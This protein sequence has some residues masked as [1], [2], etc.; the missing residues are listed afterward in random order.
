MQKL[1]ATVSSRIYSRPRANQNTKIP[2]TNMY[3]Q[4]KYQTTL[5][6]SNHAPH[7]LAHAFV[8]TCK[9]RE[10]IIIRNSD[11]QQMLLLELLE[12]CSLARLSPRDLARATWHNRPREQ[13]RQ[14]LKHSLIITTVQIS[15]T[16]WV[17]N[18]QKL[19]WRVMQKRKHHP[20]GDAQ[21][22][23]DPLLGS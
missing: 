1:T 5:I 17:P 15:F 13:V 18:P 9:C 20:R 12:Q 3:R 2:E 16:T 7:Q 22:Q 11:K 6:S 23:Q 19:I 14:S 8:G 10:C 21:K 4:I